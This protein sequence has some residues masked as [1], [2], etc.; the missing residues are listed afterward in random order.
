MPLGKAESDLQ[1]FNAQLKKFYR[2]NAVDQNAALK[3]SGTVAKYEAAADGLRDLIYGRLK[4]LGE[5][6]PDVLQKQYGALK[7]LERTFGKRATVSDRQAPLNLAQ[8]LSLAGGAGEAVSAVMAGHP[9]AA[10]AGAVPI[11]VSTAAK[12]RNSSE[13]LIRQGV[14]AMTKEAAP[15]VGESSVGQAAKTL[16]RGTGAQMGRWVPMILSDGRK[17]EVHPEDQEELL[18]RDS[19]AKVAQ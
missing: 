15:N 6:A 10:V 16:T 14:K 17:V 3:T 1:Y 8:I 18:R 4:E 2:T 12:A 19:G 5:N 11:I 9:L 13:S 7:T